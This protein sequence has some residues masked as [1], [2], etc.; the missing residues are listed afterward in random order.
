MYSTTWSAE[1]TALAVLLHYSGIVQTERIEVVSSCSLAF[2]ETSEQI[3]PPPQLCAQLDASQ[4]WLHA[5]HA[6]HAVRP[7]LTRTGR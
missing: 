6:L 2:R 5:V 1:Q 7:T 3:V 4:A